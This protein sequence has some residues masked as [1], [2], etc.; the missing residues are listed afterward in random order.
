MIGGKELGVKVGTWM[1][2]GTRRHPHSLGAVASCQRA[3][4]PI[5]LITASCTFS[6]RPRG[7]PSELCAQQGK[8]SFLREPGRP[9]FWGLGQWHWRVRW[10]VKE[11]SQSQGGLTLEIA[12]T[13]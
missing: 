3:V 12:T 6:A 11:E 13:Y 8:H 7:M 10:D 4:P 1:E 5:L 9:A 2:N